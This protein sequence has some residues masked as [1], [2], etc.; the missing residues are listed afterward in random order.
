M[1]WVSHVKWLL[2]PQGL[3]CLSLPLWEPQVYL[4]WVQ[5]VPLRLRFIKL[6]ILRIVFPFSPFLTPPFSSIESPHFSLYWFE[7]YILL[8][9]TLKMLLCIFNSKCGV[10]HH[11]CPLPGKYKFRILCFCT[12]RIVLKNLCDHRFVYFSSYFCHFALYILKLR[13]QVNPKLGFLC[14]PV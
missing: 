12:E 1:F 10:N 6:N 4:C 8:V 5:V 2:E 11:L 13:Y 3:S 9:A 14:C 7:N